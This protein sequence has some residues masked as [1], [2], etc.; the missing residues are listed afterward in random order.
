MSHPDQSVPKHIQDL[1]G[2]LQQESQQLEAARHQLQL[3]QQ[4][5]VSGA[6]DQLPRIDRELVAIGKQCATL[7]RKREA[8]SHQSGWGQQP[9]KQIIAQLPAQYVPRLT[10]LRE[11]LKRLAQ[12]V[13]Q[14]NRETRDLLSLSLQWTQDTIT[15]VR[16][17]LNPDAAS[18]N[19]QGE[20]QAKA[21]H[22][23]ASAL[24][25]TISHSA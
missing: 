12:D 4:A 10:R 25:S 21:N 7:S 2:I 20:K 8:L 6:M 3:K 14:S 13:E 5:L 9:L 22:H 16:S 15:V 24:Q 17:A 18:Y 19:A 1:V 23:P 11:Q